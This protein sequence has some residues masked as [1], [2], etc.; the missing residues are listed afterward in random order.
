MARHSRSFSILI[1][2]TLLM[3]LVL[4]A[5]G[6]Q[7]AASTAESV[8]NDVA[9]AATEANVT[10]DDVEDAVATATAVNVTE[11]DVEDAAATAEGAIEGATAAATSAVT[12]TAGT[13]ATAAA[14]GTVGM[15][16][17]AAA[18]GTAGTSAGAGGTNTCEQK[19]EELIIYASL[20]L[21][22]PSRGQTVSTANGM[23]LAL[24]QQG[25][26][27]GGYKVKFQA[28]DDSTAAAQKW[29]PE[30]ESANAQKAIRDG[31]TIYLGTFNSG[32]AAVSIPILN[33]AGIPMISPANT[34]IDLTKPG[35][36]PK[37]LASLYTKGERNYFRVVPNDAIQG[38]AGAVYAQELG[39]ETVYILHDQETYGLG[40][41]RAFQ[42]K[43]KE[44]GLTVAGFEGID[45]K[46]GSFAGVMEKVV[47]SGANL[48][49][50]GGLTDTKG[51]QLVKDLREIAGTDEVMFLGPDGI[52]DSG[53]IEAAGEAA[54]GTYGTVATAPVEKLQ[55]SGAE[56]VQLYQQEFGQKPEAYAIFGYDAMGV[57]L[58]A[59][60]QAC[61]KDPKEVL[62]ALKNLEEYSGALGT[63]S[64]D[65]DGDTTLRQM[66]AYRVKNGEWV[67]VKELS[68][69]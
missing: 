66:N 62:A 68:A 35:A 36:E 69:E 15:E 48:V 43:A 59:I 19:D 51:P 53:F 46:A 13:A 52:L 49:Y 42:G 18:T 8:G 3:G 55:G 2:L 22:G 27:A 38:P 58:Q 57:A 28:L 45:P 30:Q 60:N 1:V 20:P 29:T 64:F 31:A 34:A 17:T 21:S 67:W 37:L 11:D 50:F 54:E 32:A 25:G 61:S 7:Q 63:F 6:A 9:G 41:A 39:A 26:T 14:T 65:E 10:Q 33:A 16:A 12:A 56:F 44:L 5:C 40:I 47:D 24:D 4:A 23:Q